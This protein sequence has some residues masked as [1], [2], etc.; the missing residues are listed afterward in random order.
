VSDSAC[1]VIS[2]RKSWPAEPGSQVKKEKKKSRSGLHRGL[3]EIPDSAR[4][5]LRDAVEFESVL[6]KV[7]V[8]RKAEIAIH[9]QDAMVD[10][11][12]RVR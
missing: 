1:E 12:R 8:F 6:I 5:T 3:L 11:H 9:L 7:S 4:W 2:H 10:S